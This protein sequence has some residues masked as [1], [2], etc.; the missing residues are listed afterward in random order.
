MHIKFFQKYLIPRVGLSDLK[1]SLLNSKFAIYL[2]WLDVKQRY[3]RSKIGQFWITIS[4]ATTITMIGVVFSRVLNSPFES[5]LPYISLGIIVWSY[6]LS[7]VSDSCSAFI[8]YRSIILER[9][10][11]LFFHVIRVLSKNTIVFAHNLV[12]IPA[13]LIAC[14]A[15]VNL[16]A[17]LFVPGIVILVIF[18]ASLSLM[19]AM[20]CA[21]FRDLM[22][23]IN[24]VMQVIF[25]ITPIIWMPSQVNGGHVDLLISLN[26]FYYMIQMTRSPII[27]RSFDLNCFV[28]AFM[29]AVICWLTTILFFNKYRNRIPYWV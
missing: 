24:S 28:V 13:V 26:P 22:Q 9:P 6:M 16:H 18:L 11:P 20:V 2:G 7:T 19:F 4:M 5:Y 25:Y 23:I 14:R 10:L 29:V 12:V 8:D 17:L 21:R 1:E 15:D 3:R 27:D